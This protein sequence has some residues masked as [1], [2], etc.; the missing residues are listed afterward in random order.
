MPPDKRNRPGGGPQAAHDG[1]T[2]RT[3]VGPTVRWRVAPVPVWLG[4]Q[5]DAI[6][7]RLAFGAGP[8]CEHLRDGI[9]ADAIAALWTDALVC[10]RCIRRLRLTGDADHTC[11]RCGGLSRPTIWPGLCQ[12]SPGFL[13]VYGLCRSCHTDNP[14]LVTS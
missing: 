4:E 2:S 10:V 5:L 14:A 8:R 7:G 11:D 3:S 1:S 13:V 12:P 6:A 9:A